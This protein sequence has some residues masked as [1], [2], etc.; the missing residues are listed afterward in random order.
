MTFP[1]LDKKFER[2]VKYAVNHNDGEIMTKVAVE[3]LTK[4]RG[5]VQ[6]TGVNAKG[7]KF[8]PYSTKP[9]LVGCKSFTTSA[10]SALL[11]SKPKRKQLE[12]RTINGH[13]LAVL[14]GGYKEWRTRMGRPVDKVDFSVTNRM[15]NSIKV[16]SNQG[17]HKSGIAVI[18][19]KEK[20]EN[21][22]LAGNTE[23]RGD[24]L[25]L[26]AKEIDELKNSYNLQFLQVFREN[27]L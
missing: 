24:I 20:T 16:I 1:E 19:T 25:D 21:D 8:A 14:P 15:W 13:H 2:I 27:G 26:S 7:A 22:K 9:M 10:C 18:G 17:D 4:I 11:G 12:W 6:E 23:K 3:A 5:R